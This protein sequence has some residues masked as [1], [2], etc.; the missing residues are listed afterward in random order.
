MYNI[1]TQG[2]MAIVTLSGDVDLQTTAELKSEISR[3]Q[4]INRLDIISSDVRYIDSS[5]IA[6]LLMARQH[7]ISNRI[8]LSLSSMSMPVFRVLQIAK[9]DKLLPI[10]DVVEIDTAATGDFGID[11]A[12]DS[13]FHKP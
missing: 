3:I 1:K 10:G 2:D 13:T 4:S 8:E 7:C 11:A 5:G 6:V 12:V 9:L